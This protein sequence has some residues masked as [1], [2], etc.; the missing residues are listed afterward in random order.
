MLRVIVESLPLGDAL[1]KR[2]IVTGMCIFRVVEFKH[3]GHWFLSCL[4]AW[5]I[6]R[7]I[8]LVLMSLTTTTELFAFNW[9]FAHMDNIGVSKWFLS[10]L[11]IRNYGTIGTYR[12]PSILFTSW[13]EEICCKVKKTS[14]VAIDNVREV[15]ESQAWR[16]Y[17]MP[18]D[19]SSFS[20]SKLVY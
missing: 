9:C 18:G 10:S 5:I 13:V 2:N 11:S 16:E 3:N 7:C 4:M 19:V 15:T 8:N 6:W 12:M 20:T 17:T 1:M 14:F